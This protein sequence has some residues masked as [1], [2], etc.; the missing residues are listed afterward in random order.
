M[1][2]KKRPGAHK[3]VDENRVEQLDVV[4]DN[5]ALFSQFAQRTRGRRLAALAAAF[6]RTPIADMLAF[7]QRNARQ[8]AIEDNDT[9]TTTAFLLIITHRFQ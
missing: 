7:D 9:S 5:T 2:R 8:S 4:G 3:L 1:A 6:G